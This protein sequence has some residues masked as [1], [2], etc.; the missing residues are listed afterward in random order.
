MNRL[1]KEGAWDRLGE[2]IDAEFVAAFT[3]RGEPHTIARQLWEKYG[4]YAD[5]L[6]IYAPY[7][8]PDDMWRD[9]IAELK[10]LAG[11]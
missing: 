7:A 6:A 1:S 5:R 11:R 4:A 2:H 3:T 10:S 8:A 9:I